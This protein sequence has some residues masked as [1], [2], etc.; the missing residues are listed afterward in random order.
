MVKTSTEIGGELRRA[1]QRAELS[2][3]E[4]A[5]RA[6]VPRQV[7]SIAESGLIERQAARLMAVLQGIE[8]E[9]ADALAPTKD[10][11]EA[12]GVGK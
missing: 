2:Q 1:R 3:A 11:A 5:A 6:G 8:Q 7:V 9:Q 12:A 10:A 4:L